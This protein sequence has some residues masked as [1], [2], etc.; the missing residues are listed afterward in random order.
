MTIRWKIKIFNIKSIPTGNGHKSASLLTKEIFVS[1][2]AHQL[3]VYIHQKWVQFNWM[4]PQEEVMDI[5]SRS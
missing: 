2:A 4:F 5:E 3:F 1:P